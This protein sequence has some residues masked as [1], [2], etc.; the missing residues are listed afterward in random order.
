[1]AMGK[2][3]NAVEVLTHAAKLAK[4]PQETEMVEHM[5]MSAQE[6]AAS[7]AR[8]EE[9]SAGAQSAKQGSEESA[10]KL[11]SDSDMPHL[12]RRKE[13]VPSGPHRFVVGVLRAVRCDASNME[14]TVTSG[15]K[16]LSL[17][18]D[19]YYK[20]QFSALNF[21]PSADLKPCSDLENRP[22]KVEYVES[23][24]KSD[25][26]HLIAIELHK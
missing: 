23:A 20:I 26:P 15:A 21:Q 18:S 19:N 1:M 5:R 7:Q 2:P 10:E 13:F 6:Y 25:S 14:L 4:T 9:Q 22:A 8:N 24:N 3:Q 16:T 12:V 11:V 17:H